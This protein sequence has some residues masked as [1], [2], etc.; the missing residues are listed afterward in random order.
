[1]GYEKEVLLR[2]R[3]R[4]AQAVEQ[5]RQA[6]R[7]REQELYQRIPEM[8]Q[9]DYQIRVTMA[10]LM[11]EA[12][13]YGQDPKEAVARIKE[14]NLSLQRRR[15]QLLQEYGE[16]V[17]IDG[18]MCRRCSDTGYVGESMCDC[19]RRYCT[20]EQKKALTSVLDLSR[21]FDDFRLNLYSDQIDPALQ[22]S[23]RAIMEIVYDI[24]VDYAG[25]FSPSKGSL[26]LSGGTGLG[27][28]FLSACIAREVVEQG[29]S[30][31]YDT[32]IHLFSCLE[33]QK[34]GGATEDE[35]RTA[36][37][38]YRCDLLIL[39]DL[40]TEMTT[41]FIAPA[42]YGVINGR[43]LERKA[44]IISSNYSVEQLSQR[45]T[46]QIASRLD[47]EFRRLNF[48]GKDIRRMLK[49]G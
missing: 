10:E 8:K 37:R 36:D 43:I 34:F 15:T 20:R 42:L 45:Y 49:Q 9:L 35:L 25:H 24:C 22:A 17:P 44:T 4:Y 6:Q 12:F 27:K 40:G 47:G 39:D 2:A 26:Y 11:G 38:I 46:P 30:V 31:V 19:F 13:R 14:K 5:H 41:A 16:T 7:Q 21:S 28:T 32:A 33:K 18:P 29:F 48:V 3:E 1:M 23:P